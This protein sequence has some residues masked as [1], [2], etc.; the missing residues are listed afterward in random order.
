MQACI[1]SSETP[2]FTK[3]QI[4]VILSE[5]KLSAMSK[6]E[7]VVVR[8]LEELRLANK[9]EDL[10]QVSAW[11]PEDTSFPHFPPW[12]NLK[13]ILVRQLQFI[14]GHFPEDQVDADTLSWMTGVDSER[15]KNALD[16]LVVMEAVSDKDGYYEIT[17]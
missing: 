15:I 1:S 13:G 5:K 16:D 9:D 11:I 4:A 6:E 14:H 12:S 8:N 2:F 3:E 7:L 10:D 17:E